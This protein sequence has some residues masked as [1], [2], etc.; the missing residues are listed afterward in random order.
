MSAQGGVV[1]LYKRG[2]AFTGVLAP[3]LFFEALCGSVKWVTFQW[4]IQYN[5][6]YF[7]YT[8]ILHLPDSLFSR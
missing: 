3:Y 8:A 7:G 5:S 6:V 4:R 1:R 2:Y